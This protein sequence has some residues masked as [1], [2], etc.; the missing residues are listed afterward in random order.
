MSKYPRI[1]NWISIKKY[2]DR[3]IYRVKNHFSQ[4]TYKI[5]PKMMRVLKQL[6][7]KTDPYRLLKGEFGSSKREADELL[8]A[9]KEEGLIRD[10]RRIKEIPMGLTLVRIY[11]SERYRNISR[12]LLFLLALA[13]IPVVLV[14]TIGLGKI[15]GNLL[16]VYED[17]HWL[18]DVAGWILGFTLG[19]TA[20]ELG[21]AIAAIA[22]SGKVMELGVMFRLGPAAYT[23]ID[24]DSIKSRHGK[25]VTLMAGTLVNL[26]FASLC[27]WIC[28]YLPY[29]RPVVFDMGFMNYMLFLT[30]LVLIRG[31]DG[32]AVMELLV[33][34]EY[35]FSHSLGY[36]LEYFSNKELRKEEAESG[37]MEVGM[38]LMILLTAV[39]PV[40][41][42]LFFLCVIFGW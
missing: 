13:F 2:K 32:M 10:S 4:E 27:M 16:F 35:I 1:S 34:R 30:N 7:G 31:L 23:L 19:L 36:L 20:H 41:M 39:T 22:F 6:D 25:V 5:G 26:M 15:I 28:P 17:S 14:G 38:S 11:H 18:M 33:G 40:A 12:V 3:D 21:H 42:G 29:L 37:I 8:E 9:L 24:M